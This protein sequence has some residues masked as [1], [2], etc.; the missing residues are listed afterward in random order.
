MPDGYLLGDRALYLAAFANV[1]ESIS[2]DGVVPSDGPPTALKSIVSFDNT[3]KADRIDLAK[4]FTNEF[5]LKAK[6]KFKA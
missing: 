2:I 5:A 1:R 3:V 6:Q 4:T